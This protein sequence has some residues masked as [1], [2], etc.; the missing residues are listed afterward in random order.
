[1]IGL[2][3]GFY[4]VLDSDGGADCAEAPLRANAA[5]VSFD[6]GRNDIARRA[7]DHSIAHVTM[8]AAHLRQIR[9][10][11]LTS[12]GAGFC[13]W[14]AWTRRAGIARNLTMPTRI[15]RE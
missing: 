15:G 7:L 6:R 12:A 3:V 4:S 1:M 2:S 13:S 10:S 5:H 9:K 14:F 11:T 8:A